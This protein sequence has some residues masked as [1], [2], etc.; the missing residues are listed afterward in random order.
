[1]STANRILSVLVL[2]ASIGAIV[3]ATMLF[4]KR[5]GVVAGR[6]NMAQ[7]IADNSN[8]MSKTAAEN[9]KKVE[10]DP[11]EMG[12][13]KGQDVLGALKK[14]DD[15]TKSI[16]KQRNELA[17]QVV[18]LTSILAEH[19]SDNGE[20]AEFQSAD[21]A[22]VKTNAEKFAEI[23]AKAEKVIAL[24]KQTRESYIA[25]VK[26]FENA[27]N[28]QTLGDSVL[29][30][31][32]PDFSAIDAGLR[33]MDQKI[34]LMYSHITSLNDIVP[35]DY[36][37]KDG[38]MSA[39]DYKSYLQDQKT[40]MEAFKARFDQLVKQV[41]ELTAKV[42]ELTAKVEELTAKVEK[43][44]EERDQYKANFEAEREAKEKLQ[45]EN[46]QLNEKLS[47][48][49]KKLKDMEKMGIAAAPAGAPAG[50][51]A[52]PTPAQVSL[53]AAAL[54]KVEGKIIYVDKESGFVVLNIGSE[55]KVEVKDAK[56]N[57]VKTALV[58]PA[59]AIMTVATSLDP[60]TAKFVCKIQVYQVAATR[61]MAN[62]LPGNAFPKV[63][64]IVYFS[65]SD[66]AN[67][68]SAE[69]K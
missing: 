12:V 59:N 14:F 43:L 5:E 9:P 10:I 41:E 54:N 58:M 8:K 31:K 13:D 1:M 45:N 3:L 32:N 35:D 33:A 65:A 2:L 30:P 27:L 17:A 47:K 69:N 19:N 55:T 25:A 28:M 62:I 7:A 6:N 56:G 21:L 49:E 61:A 18:E 50:V 36:K 24:Y 67:S 22:D 20:Y 60:A 23:K 16:L 66:I 4:N 37:V 52:A 53:Q 34:R 63:G 46:N 51:A 40:N 42:E 44:T 48:I 68:K 15:V 57:K 64:D 26:L 38:S 11:A 29:D 39:E